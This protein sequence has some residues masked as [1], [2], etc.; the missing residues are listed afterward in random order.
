MLTIRNGKTYVNGGAFDERTLYVKDGHFVSAEEAGEVPDGGVP[1]EV[2]ASGC[3]V[4][5]GL[6][7]LHFHGCVGFTVGNGTDEAIETIAR[8]EAA[9][10]I[11]QIC[12]ATST[13]AE[14]TLTA[15]AQSAC[16]F[17]KRQNIGMVTEDDGTDP[18]PSPTGADPRDPVFASLVG[19]HMEGPF[20]S[21][22]KRGAQ[23]PIFLREPD[24]AMAERLRIASGGLY[25][26]MDL[27]P[28]LPGAD[29]F[30]LAEKEHAVIS[31]AHSAADYE[32]SVHA[33]EL[34]VSHMTHLYNGMKG[35][36]HRAPGPVMAAMD[37][38]HVEAELI[39][40]GVHVKAP[41]VRATFRFLGKERIIMISDSLAV[42]GRP[43]GVYLFG[44]QPVRKEGKLCTLEG[45]DT[46]AGS[47]ANLMQ[48]MVNA[49]REMGIPLSDAVLCAAENPVRCLG[50]SEQFGTL[51][52]GKW[53]SFVLLD[54]NDLSVRAVYNRGV[55]IPVE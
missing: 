9:S 34:G 3:F 53:A 33:M 40:D 31:L 55:K 22:E 25:K 19:L 50:L 15:A 7:D 14:D 6:T 41:V 38:P 30:I 54:E 21:Y 26:I 4:I 24:A 12:P 48:G 8:Y 42:A 43:D 29:E 17:A 45:T 18:G 1:E 51:D 49:V 2:D 39:C 44:R 47:C 52:P 23:D 32:T 5:P 11:T 46:I 10:G 16:R 27:A 37:C 28:E 36:A 20:F 35:I 13:A